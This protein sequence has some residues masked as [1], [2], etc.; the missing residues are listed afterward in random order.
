MAHAALTSLPV[1]GRSR[2]PTGAP[3]EAASPA[4]A[5]PGASPRSRRIAL[6]VAE[7]A[8]PGGG[9]SPA[10]TSRRWS[11]SSAS[12]PAWAKTSSAR[13]EGGLWTVE[14][15][16]AGDAGARLLGPPDRRAHVG[17]RGL[18]RQPLAPRALAPPR[19]LDAPQDGA[20]RRRGDVRARRLP[21]RS[22]RAP[23]PRAAAVDEQ[24]HRRP[25]RRA[26][27]ELECEVV[28]V[29]TGAGGAAAAY[30][31]ARRGRAVLLLEAGDF[32]SARASTAA[33]PRPFSSATSSAG[34]RSRSATSPRACGPAAA[35][36]AALTI[37]SGTCYRAPEHTLQRWA[38]RYGLGMLERRA[39]ALLRSRRGHARRRP[40]SA[41]A[42]RRLGARRGARRGSARISHHPLQRNAPG[43]DG[44]GVC[45]FGCP[46]GA[47]RS[48]D[49]SYVPEALR[50]APS[51]LTAAE[52][53]HV[54][55]IEGR[56]R[57]V[58][59]R[60]AS[61][62]ALRV[63]ADAVIVAGGALLT[64]LLLRRSG[65]AL[66]SGWLGKNLSV[67]P[68]SKVMALFGETIDM[69]ARHPAEPGHRRLRARRLDVRGRL[70]AALTSPR[71]R[72][73]GSAAA[74][75]ISSIAT[76]TSRPSAS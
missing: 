47:K 64:P 56:A 18:E 45:C 51:S 6:A 70:D 61:G 17:P 30:E 37:N 24:G 22:R 76:P 62:H 71:W 75:W 54:D 11:A 7:A 52:V 27:L 43:C 13:L 25:R 2:P 9:S 3:L 57:G 19:D 53:L 41:V 12:S 33:P 42:P 16:D 72:R 31:L 67:H 28:V 35:S 65:L 58:T 40:G 63:R 10:A 32:T 4:P 60:L 15:L 29:G 23:A 1:L 44:Q 20:L 73:R 55:V 68:A 38:E 26:D 39:R 48:T 5:G 66:G 74:S 34:R 50:S 14:S 69:L 21:P 59:A 8:M 46:T 36:A 49:V